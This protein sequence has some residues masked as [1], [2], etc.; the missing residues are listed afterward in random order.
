MLPLSIGQCLE[1]TVGM[2]ASVVEQDI[3]FVETCLD[4]GEG[5]FDLLGLSDVAG[6][7]GNLAR[8]Q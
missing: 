3:D 5:G 7:S 1:L 4:G 8:R 2:F 6:K